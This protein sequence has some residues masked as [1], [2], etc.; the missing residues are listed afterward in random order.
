MNEAFRHI[1]PL[2][3]FRKPHHL[4]GCFCL[5]V[6]LEESAIRI[7][8]KTQSGRYASQ[9]QVEANRKFGSSKGEDLRHYL[10]AHD[11]QDEEL[12]AV[13]KDAET[14]LQ[15]VRESLTE[16][17]REARSRVLAKQRERIASS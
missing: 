4:P 13:S 12:N 17:R 11:L 14:T 16:A 15:N 10:K 6:L 2:H 1:H 3:R 9:A 7:E 5:R 8:T